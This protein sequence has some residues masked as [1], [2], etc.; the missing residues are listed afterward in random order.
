MAGFRPTEIRKPTDETEFE[1]NCVVL[2]AAILNDPNVSR[3]GT[4][5]IGQDGVDIKGLREGDP[6][7]VVG[8]QCKVK[9]GSQNLT[10]SEIDKEV[11]LALQ[12]V[13]A[14]SEYIIVTTGKNSTKLQQ[15]ALS[16]SKAHNEAGRNIIIDVWGWDTLH[17]KINQYPEAKNAFD[18]G[19]SP[20]LAAQNEKLD[21]LIVS[22]SDLATKSDLDAIAS[23]LEQASVPINLQLPPEFADRELRAQLSS[24]L[25]RRGFACS[26]TAGELDALV[27]RF[28]RGDLINSSSAMKAEVLDRAARAS[29]TRETREKSQDYRDRAAQLEPSRDF[30]IVDA[31]LKD[32]HG[33]TNEAL[34]DLRS[35][36]DI[37]AHSALLTL[38]VRQRG[39][40]A[41]I[42][43][44]HEENLYTRELTPLLALN[45]TL[46][47]IQYNDYTGALQILSNSPSNFFQ[48]LP[49]LLL[50]RAKLRLTTLL[51]RDQKNLIFRSFPIDP[52]HLQLAD[53]P[54]KEATCNLAQ[55][56]LKLL[57]GQLEKLNVEYLSD[58]LNELSLWLRLE[59]ESLRS[60]AYAQLTAE[61]NDPKTTLK[62]VRL[63]LAYQM[64]FNSDALLKKLLRNK[65][66]GGWNTDERFAAL[67][68]I[69][70]GD[71]P[72]TIAKFLEDHRQDLFSQKDLSDGFLAAIEVEALAR[73]GRFELAFKRLEQYRGSLLDNEQ[74]EEIFAGITAI[75][76]GDEIE[77][78]RARYAASRELGELRALVAGLRARKNTS[79]LADYAPELAR[80]TRTR[81]DFDLAIK[82]LYQENRDAE[83][84]ALTDELPD[85]TSLDLDYIA[86]KG[87]SLYRMGEV[88][89]ARTI[90]RS[91]IQ[92]RSDSSDRE[93]A[94][95]TAIETGDW[96]NLQVILAQEL[97]RIDSLTAVD[98]MRLARL[99]LESGSPYVDRFRDAAL[100]KAPDDPQVNLFAY[101]LATERGQEGL[102]T[103]AQDWFQRAIDLSGDDGPVQSVSLRDLAEQSSG[104]REGVD[105]LDGALRAA[106]MPMFIV[107]RALNRRL[108]DL[109]LG[110]ANRN[111]HQYAAPSYPVFAFSA[112]REQSNLER[113]LSVALD[114]T[115]LITLEFLGLLGVTLDHFEHI[116]LAPKTLMFL[117]AERQFIRVQQPSQVKKAKRIQSL[118]AAGRLKVLPANGSR[119]AEDAVMGRELGALLSNAATENG[120]VVRTA[121]VPRVGSYLDEEVDMEEHTKTLVDTHSVLAF[122][123][124]RGKINAALNKY[125]V[126]YLSR[127][128]SGWGHATSISTDTPLYLD[129]LALTY[130]DH[131]DMLEILTREISTIYIH[132]DAMEQVHQT[133]AYSEYSEDLSA[134]VEAI[135]KALSERI[136]IGKISF[137]ARQ[138][139][140]SASNTGEDETSPD[141]APTMDL[142]ID[143][144]GADI[145]VAD[146]RYMNQRDIWEDERKNQVGT[147]C[148]LDVLRSL[149]DQGQMSNA[150]FWTARHRLRAGGY[151]AIPLETN[152]VLHWLELAPATGQS[153]RETPELL[154][155]RESIAL[156]MTS[157]AFL[158]GETRW[159]S[160]TFLALFQAI[161]QLWISPISADV[162]AIRADWLLSIFPDPVEWCVRYDD[163]ATWETAK[164]QATAQ[165]AALMVFSGASH[166]RQQE[167]FNWLDRSFLAPMKHDDPERFAAS[168]NVLKSYI[169]KLSEVDHEGI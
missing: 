20:A 109:T 103:S 10:K 138:P 51:P 60:A 85:L 154:S 30:S 69:L 11:K 3:I 91:L 81:Q 8:V 126:T 59:T 129:G 137:S 34:I 42:D 28:E 96:A 80:A 106:E 57:L 169:G 49:V 107:A 68:I 50:L 150:D 161:R 167:Y 88:V 43:W 15:H 101:T 45:L 87:W 136:E 110:Q 156:P 12:F 55:E 25:K 13:P 52:R 5:G 21:S 132:P 78:H 163:E 105:K 46:Y 22:H 143:L 24:I 146:D 75:E 95:N 159:L 41:A 44:A 118:V 62:R 86:I 73:S 47:L 102:G 151:Y 1:K 128:D 130:F 66:L 99:A 56:D 123:R 74:S 133:L 4:R 16:L 70:H 54:E 83:V 97:E 38:I 23:R 93:L 58:H 61:L 131:L 79:L 112:A 141:L 155:I 32:A 71:D 9:S 144:K 115:A 19:F 117:F 104:W 140:F 89:E 63:A 116:I 134:A 124:D 6:N 158:T 120:L 98:S 122:L 165:S 48:E 35:R 168:I 108:L 113:E 31:L 119:N 26:N 149:H 17:E 2:F 27:D 100:S 139:T 65:E 114:V 84:I 92:K 166:E 142:L 127:V 82:S 145:V 147:Y 121:P 164:H 90:A 64:D 29:T 77:R 37:E 18:P 7:R 157:A 125:A 67:Q 76:N 14:L 94:I 148:T 36:T 135:R 111:S 39:L 152:E 53:G 40:K 72:N 33:Q 160:N 162:A 153:I